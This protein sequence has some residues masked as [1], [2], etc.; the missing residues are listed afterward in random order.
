MTTKVKARKFRVRNTAGAVSEAEA[1]EIEAG[2][3][4]TEAETGSERRETANAGDAAGGAP[5]DPAAETPKS[6]AEEIDDIRKENLTG[7][8]LRMARR[9]AQKQG[10]SPSSDYDAVRLLRA[11]GI[12]PFKR[13]NMLELVVSDETV[14]ATQQKMLSALPAKV[15]EKSEVPALAVTSEAERAQQIMDMQ[16]DIVRRRRRRAAMLGIRLL[17]FVLLPTFVAGYYYHSVATPMYSTHSEFIIQKAEQSGGGGIG[18]LFAG[19]GLANSQDSITVQGYLNSRDALLRLDQDEGFKAHFSDPEIDAIQRLA[20]DASNEDAYKVFRKHVKIGFDTTEGII[21]MDVIAADPEVS[22]RF[23]RQLIAYAEQQVDQLTARLRSDQM[24]GA[25]EGRKEAEGKMF[26]AQQRIVELQEKLGVLNPESEIAAV[27]SQIATL[28]GDLLTER[29]NL[30]TTLD[31]A[32][33]N[34][35]KVNAAENKIEEIEK[36]IAEKRA[37][38]TESSTASGSLA[39]ITAEMMVAQSELETRQEMLFQAEAQYESARMEANRQ[40][41]YLSLAVSPL[42]PDE[43][44]YP[45]VFENTVL[46]FLIFSGIYLMVSLTASILREQV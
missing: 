35:A 7:R 16:R 3:I 32:Q 44:S 46:A 39:R 43:P 27:M 22:A 42:A 15:S 21:K 6:P 20:P 1:A 34:Q 26:A 45:R 36:L 40:V 10:L 41:R 18:G 12:D 4:G 24:Q 5:D 8:Q 11:K 30:R 23:S 17:F 33:P 28:E 29:L 13:S 14:D 9:V 19:T 31:N 38:L 2:E 37:E 25:D